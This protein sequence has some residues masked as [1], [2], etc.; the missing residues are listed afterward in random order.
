MSES[1]IFFVSHVSYVHF[2]I[3]M[4]LIKTDTLQI[5]VFNDKIFLEKKKREIE[6]IVPK[7]VSK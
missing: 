1:I 4:I 5:I 7:R 2:I 3:H 6:I